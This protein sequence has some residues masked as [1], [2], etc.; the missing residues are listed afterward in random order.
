MV[1]WVVAELKTKENGKR[2]RE[3]KRWIWEKDL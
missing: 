3:I 2:T 1:V